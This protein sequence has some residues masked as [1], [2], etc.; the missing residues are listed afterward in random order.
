MK[1]EQDG[2]YFFYKRI[3]LDCIMVAYDELKYSSLTS[4]GGTR[5]NNYIGSTEKNHVEIR[6][7]TTNARKI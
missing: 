3:R 4:N 7:Y 6:T 5:F 1:M 2:G